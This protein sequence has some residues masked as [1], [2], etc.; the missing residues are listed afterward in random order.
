MIREGASFVA[1]FLSIGFAQCS[2]FALS[3]GE[4]PAPSSSTSAAPTGAE[5]LCKSAAFISRLESFSTQIDVSKL[6]RTPGNVTERTTAIGVAMQRP[7]KLAITIKDGREISYAWVSNGRKMTTYTAGMKKSTRSR[8]PGSIAELAEN[9]E[10]ETVKSL[11]DN[12]LLLEVLLM[13]R[14][15][16][17]IHSRFAAFEG[18][19]AEPLD[20]KAVNRIKA[21]RNTS[22]I[23]WEIA[24]AS[25]PEPVPLRIFADIT[26]AA[27]KAAP[28]AGVSSST[29]TVAFNAWQINPDLPA[30]AF[31]FTPP[32]GTEKVKSYFEPEKPSPLLNKAAPAA[33]LTVLDGSRAELASL[34]GKIVL[35]DFWQIH[36]IPCIYGLPRLDALA[37]EYKKKGVTIFAIDEADTAG[38]V[39]AF[40]KDKAWGSNLKFASGSGAVSAAYAIGSTPTSVLI[41]AAGT[42]RSVHKFLDE[43]AKAALAA[44]FDA[45]LAGRELPKPPP[46]DNDD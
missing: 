19:G 18:A 21:V 25:G 36:C 20:G 17:Q 39:R 3:A 43:E 10:M 2:Q 33:A 27:K 28:Q 14:P 7:D 12:I 11:M 31:E 5:L 37:R 38:E 40:M 16:E 24:L 44:E 35:L 22:G 15:C 13:D 34:R 41:D 6:T 26:E 23:A 32:P 1:L 42:V 9:A 8:A 29:M 45:L 4:L 30:S 46:D